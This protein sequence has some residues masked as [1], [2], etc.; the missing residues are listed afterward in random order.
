MITYSKLAGEK[1]VLLKDGVNFALTYDQVD[2][3]ANVLKCMQQ[4]IEK[5]LLQGINEGE[6]IMWII[7]IPGYYLPTGFHPDPGENSVLIQIGDPEL[8]GSVVAANNFPI[9]QHQFRKQHQ[10]RFLDMTYDNLDKLSPELQDR[11]RPALITDDQA[12]EIISI[13]VDAYESKSNV[14]VHCSAGICRSGA[15]VEV[16][17]MMGFTDISNTRIPNLL[18]KRKLI[19]Q[20][21]KKGYLL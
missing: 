2:E 3:L 16:G 20:L 15:V 13:L 17:V 5:A 9:P 8:S 6:S 19:D 21:I 4:E 1:Y 10:L 14:V 18:V 12:C 11:Y 7:N